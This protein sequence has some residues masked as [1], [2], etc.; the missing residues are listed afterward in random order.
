[1][2]VQTLIHPRE[3]QRLERQCAFYM[4]SIWRTLEL[5]N[6]DPNALEKF[7]RRYLESQSLLSQAYHA[8]GERC[9]FPDYVPENP[10]EIR[11][12]VLGEQGE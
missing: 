12:V 5:G 2:T 7:G 1:M 11:L 3:I 9:P 8:Q 10:E 4:G 6:P